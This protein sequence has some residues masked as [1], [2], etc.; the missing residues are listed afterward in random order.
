M[1][2][3]FLWRA[4]FFFS[5]FRKPAGWMSS[6]SLI[7]LTPSSLKRKQAKVKKL[8]FFDDFL[9]HFVRI[10][11]CPCSQSHHAI[12]KSAIA[13]NT[14]RRTVDCATRGGQNG[15]YL[16][17]PT[18]LPVITYNKNEKIYFAPGIAAFLFYEHCYI[19]P[20]LIMIM[21]IF[22]SQ[23]KEKFA[24]NILH[25]IIWCC[26]EM[27]LP[28]FECFPEGMSVSNNVC[29]ERLTLIAF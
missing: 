12:Q 28:V 18:K 27:K 13:K 22:F 26:V 24:T 2:C 3:F 1:I 19:C 15:K 7:Y 29:A 11:P 16:Q 20:P 4:F 9:S 25:D 10:K 14:K 23:R 5:C 6:L 21:I 17:W 8:F